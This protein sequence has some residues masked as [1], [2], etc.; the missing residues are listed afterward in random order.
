[1]VINV[2]SGDDGPTKQGRSPDEEASRASLARWGVRLCC[3][4]CGAVI[5]VGHAAESRRDE[6][7]SDHRY[8]GVGEK[9]S[10]RVS[11]RGHSFDF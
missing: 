7:E 1:M 10:G 8:V 2:E 9:L 11:M 6:V 5:P 4:R 3:C